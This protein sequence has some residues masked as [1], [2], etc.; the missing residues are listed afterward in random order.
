[1]NWEHERT[2]DEAKE[3]LHS[4]LNKD[5][6]YENYRDE[7]ADVKN[8]WKLNLPRTWDDKYRT[9][10][11]DDWCPWC[12]AFCS[13]GLFES[14]IVKARMDVNH[15]YSS[16]IWRSDWHFYNMFPGKSHSDIV[17]RFSNERM[18]REITES[19][20]GSVKMSLERLGK[21]YCT[22]DCEALHETERFIRFCESCLQDPDTIVIYESEC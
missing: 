5:K 11:N 16:S 14:K 21:A 8:T 12:E 10:H 4:H 13:E 22:A 9:V 20:V 7:L 15:S 19:E 1:M 3:E 18:Y 17:N 2:F 6:T